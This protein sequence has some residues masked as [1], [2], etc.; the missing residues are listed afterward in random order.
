MRILHV[1][2]HPPSQVHSCAYAAKGNV[3]SLIDYEAVVVN[4]LEEDL[5]ILDHFAIVANK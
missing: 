3:R 1:K 4:R 2:H 5:L